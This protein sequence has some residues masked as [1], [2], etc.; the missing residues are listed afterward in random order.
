MNFILGFKCY[1]DWQHCSIHY[2]SNA[3][4]LMAEGG[5]SLIMA[6]ISKT[7]SHAPTKNNHFAHLIQMGVRKNTNFITNCSRTL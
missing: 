4:G 3:Y 1:E 7:H 6:P 5:W 2:F